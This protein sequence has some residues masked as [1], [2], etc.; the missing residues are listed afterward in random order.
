MLASSGSPEN[1]HLAMNMTQQITQ[2]F[3]C[4]TPVRSVE[5][6]VPKNNLVSPIPGY[7]LSSMFVKI[8]EEVQ[9][10][11]RLLAFK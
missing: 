5:V 8:E 2:Y 11:T 6:E 4:L 9:D 7:G 10:Y 3:W 1:G